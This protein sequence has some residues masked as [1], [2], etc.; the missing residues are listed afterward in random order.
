MARV[1]YLS[2]KVK[3]ISG[4]F[5]SFSSSGSVIGMKKQYYGKN[6]LLVR[7]GY[8]I[9]NVTSRPEIYDLAH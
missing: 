9:Y 6:A 8:Y 3:N 4:Q 1:K 2:A 5:P 7:Q